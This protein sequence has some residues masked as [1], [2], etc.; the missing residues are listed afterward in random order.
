MVG[1][2][3]SPL[4]ISVNTDTIYDYNKIMYDD[5][6]PYVEA[7]KWVGKDYDGIIEY[8]YHYTSDENL[9]ELID[10]LRSLDTPSNDDQIIYEAIEDGMA[11]YMEGT[12]SLDETV[13]DISSTINIYVN[14]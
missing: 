12:K 3:N 4:G 11:E 6:H 2:L 13:S 7:G 8:D 10:V 9:E 1:D 5:V 14:E